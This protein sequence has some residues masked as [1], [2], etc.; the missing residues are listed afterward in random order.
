MKPE[1]DG[2]VV[3]LVAKISCKPEFILL[4]T[5][6][7]EQSFLDSFQFSKDFPETDLY[8]HVQPENHCDC[9]SCI[10]VL[11]RLL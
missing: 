3:I 7:S 5:K 4:R 10:S 8:N 6:I 11:Y 1:N 2:C 9:D